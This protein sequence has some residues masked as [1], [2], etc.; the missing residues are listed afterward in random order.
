MRIGGDLVL[1]SRTR[2]EHVHMAAKDMKKLEVR[3]LASADF[4]WRGSLVVVNHHVVQLEMV[5][6][7]VGP[8]LGQEVGTSEHSM[9]GITNCLVRT[10]TWSILVRRVSSHIGSTL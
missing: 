6:E 10:L 4:K 7:G 2:W 5:M 8:E 9:K 1:A 3:L